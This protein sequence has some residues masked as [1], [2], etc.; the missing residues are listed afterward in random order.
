[1]ADL[2]IPM[3][4]P[5]CVRL[6]A[7]GASTSARNA[8]AQFEEQ[9]RTKSWLSGC[10][11]NRHRLTMPQEVPVTVSLAGGPLPSSVREQ[12]DPAAVVIDDQSVPQLGFRLLIDVKGRVGSC[13]KSAQPVD[14]SLV[15]CCYLEIA[16]LGMRRIAP[17]MAHHLDAGHLS[18]QLGEFI[19][20]ADCHAASLVK[21]T[22]QV[23]RHDLLDSKHVRL[24]ST[25]LLSFHA[26]SIPPKKAATIKR[27]QGTSSS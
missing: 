24:L 25:G 11:S 3:N 20:T 16:V 14:G 17:V 6:A 2:A 13:R 18:H 1:M 5:S 19:I 4:R 12:Q 21:A 27:P 23:D 9:S 15:F 22:R 10:S 7:R 8:P 26:D